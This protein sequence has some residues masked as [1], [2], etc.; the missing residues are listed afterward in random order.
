MSIKIYH[1][2]IYFRIEIREI[3]NESLMN[4]TET[5]DLESKNFHWQQ[6]VHGISERIFYK[7]KNNCVTDLDLSYHEE[8]LKTLDNNDL[9]YSY[10]NVDDFCLQEEV[11]M[12]IILFTW[13]LYV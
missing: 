6:K 7:D 4:S 13:N 11:Y 12:L 3:I 1:L 9:L 10:V 5:R 2:I 8:V